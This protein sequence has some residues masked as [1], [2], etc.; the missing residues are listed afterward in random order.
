MKSEDWQCSCDNRL[1]TDCPTLNMSIK[2]TW[3]VDTKQ[4]FYGIP[5]IFEQTSL[6]K[7]FS[8]TTLRVTKTRTLVCKVCHTRKLCLNTKTLRKPGKCVTNVCNQNQGVTALRMTLKLGL[9]EKQPYQSSPEVLLCFVLSVRLIPKIRHQ[10][11]LKHR[12]SFCFPFAH[13]RPK[14]EVSKS[15][16]LTRRC[17]IEFL[18][19]FVWKFRF[20]PIP[21]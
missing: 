3:L 2:D 19:D 21:L 20:W 17:E 15:S 5:N 12:D 4:R 11:S 16:S 14:L 18:R 6:C 13:R 1:Y 8:Y 10:S 7:T 9:Y